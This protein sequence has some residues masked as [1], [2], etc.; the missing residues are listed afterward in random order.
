MST[1]KCTKPSV[2]RIV[3]EGVKGIA[4]V[5]HFEVSEEDSKRTAMR[6]AFGKPDDYVA[7]GVYARLT[8]NG[9]LMMTDTEYEWRSNR[10]AVRLA[11]GDVLIGGLGIGMVLVPI[12]QNPDVHSVTV[13]EKYQDVVDLVE[14]GVRC[15]VHYMQAAKLTIHTGDILEWTPYKG[16]TFDFIYFD[17]WENVC[18]DNLA[19]MTKLKRRFARRL[20]RE[21]PKAWMGCWEEDRLRVRAKRERKQERA[22]RY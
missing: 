2:A 8:V 22:W 11:H 12:L 1:G 5:D 14:T 21:N 18:T 15:S 4:T 10:R 7:P 20:N 17:I 16:Q 13:V 6:A 3:P 19:E 9:S